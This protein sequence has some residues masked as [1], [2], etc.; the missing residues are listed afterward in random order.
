M[1]AL[2]RAAVLLFFPMCVSAQE[3]TVPVPAG[4]RMEGVPPIPVELAEGLSPYAS[5]RMATFQAWHPV[6]RRM[7]ITTR[8]GNV[9]QVHQVRDPGGARTQLTF[10]ADGVTGAATYDKAGRAMVFQRDTSGGSR[11]YQLFRHDL[12]TGTTTLLTDG[13]SLNSAPVWAR[14]GNRIAYTSTRRAAADRD[15]HVMDPSDP[16]TDRL[17]LQVTGIW[18]VL[19]W[20]PG[21]R[22]LLVREA[23]STVSET[24]LWR[25]NVDTGDKT[26]VTERGGRG[27]L[28]QQAFYSPDGKSI[29]ALGD[30]ESDVPRLL[31]RDVSGGPWTPVVTDDA[32]VEMFEVSPDGRRIALVADVG[33]L[34]EIRIVDVRTGQVRPVTGL[35]PGRI[36]SLAWHPTGAEVAVTFAGARTFSDVY[37]IDAARDRIDR[38]T[39]S[40]SGGA[41]PESLPDAEIVRWKSFDGLM[42][43]GVLYRPPAHFTGPRPVIVNVHGGP[44]LRERPRGLGR[45]NY[46]RNEMGIA[47]V[48][49]NIRG[50]SG[51]GRAYEQADNGM[52]REDAVRDIGALL[53]WIASE[54]GLDQDRVLITGGSY[55]G[56][57]AYASAIA[58]GDRLRGAIA[59]FAISDFVSYLEASDKAQLA[60]E[61]SRR[62]DR[63]IEYG[64]PSDPDV[65]AFLQ[66]ISPLTH[67]SQIRIPLLVIQGGRDNLVPVGQAEQMV[68]A[69][70]ASG[71]PLW[72]VLFE[73]AGHETLPGQANNFNLYT[74][75]LFARAFLLH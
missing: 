47:I 63:K 64:D 9:D 22:E 57:I 30:F 44:A 60:T 59:G 31:R 13:R 8:F 53:D 58:Y 7:L 50:S 27:V 69:V 45:S 51:F 1:R 25:V 56:Y 72:Y 67:A 36:A 10:Y 23:P 71:T 62:V 16:T 29:Y 14:R 52:K 42:I 33:A 28:W 43:P 20:S 24:Y 55:G 21:D 41:T 40:E 26:T 48:Y 65:R 11:L 73:D 5:F 35:P 32:P 49:P 15:I 6:D 70:R 75:I 68:K 3:G 74:W 17:V 54:P 46:F 39:S 61:P 12:A 37:S 4:I 66:R 2:S 19:D 18:S 38:W 34:S